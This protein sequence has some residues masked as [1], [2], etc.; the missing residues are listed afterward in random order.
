MLRL[1][2][3]YR[4]CGRHRL[5]LC[6]RRRRGRLGGLLSH[7]AHKLCDHFFF[8]N[9]A[10]AAATATATHNLQLS[11]RPSSLQRRRSLTFLSTSNVIVVVFV[12]ALIPMLRRSVSPLGPSSSY[13]NISHSLLFYVYCMNST[14]T[15]VTRVKIT[16]CA[17][18]LG[19]WFAIEQ[20]GRVTIR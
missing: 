17:G 12:V 5:R 14:A 16:L 10:A 9:T 4:C 13:A 2:S 18:S 20:H 1:V 3:S 11:A 8:P 19:L 7:G 15:A 6:R